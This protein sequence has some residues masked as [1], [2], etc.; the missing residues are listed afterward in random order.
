M[1]LPSYLIPIK[2]EFSHNGYI[3]DLISHSCFGDQRGVAHMKRL[4]GFFLV[5]LMLVVIGN[6][7]IST[8]QAKSMQ[9]FKHGDAIDPIE[10]QVFVP[11]LFNNASNQLSQEEQIE[12]LLATQIN[13]NAEQVVGTIFEDLFVS[14]VIQQP[15]SN[16]NWISNTENTLTSKQTA[17][18]T[19][20]IGLAAYSHLTGAKFF[21][22]AL[23]QTILI[24]MGDGAFHLYLVDSNLQFQAIDP[25]NP[26]SAYIHPTTS[27]ILTF[28]QLEQSL[29]DGSGRLVLQTDITK[30]GIA[31]WGILVVTAVSLTD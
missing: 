23:G 15:E 10:Y 6:K 30:D 4:N 24:V 7:S 14:P 12:N 5:V 9:A 22:L 29:Y 8:A 20:D 11:I 3:N 2:D 27:E 25:G 28:T 31:Q 26:D 13:G 16:P 19:G 1:K 21:G 17:R 18:L